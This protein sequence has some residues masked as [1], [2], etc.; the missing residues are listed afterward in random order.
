MSLVFSGDPLKGFIFLAS[1]TP[2]EVTV[3]VTY[4]TRQM[5]KV[6][7]YSIIVGKHVY[8]NFIPC[9]RLSYVRDNHRRKVLQLES[10]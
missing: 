3:T 5:E 6:F 2:V 7:K 8:F 4:A 9:A 10:Y 1:T